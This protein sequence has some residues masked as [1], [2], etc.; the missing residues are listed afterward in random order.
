MFVA[1]QAAPQAVIGIQSA[2]DL[3]VRTA[4]D[5]I[6]ELATVLPLPHVVAIVWCIMV[7]VLHTSLITHLVI[8]A[9]KHLAAGQQDLGCG[10]VVVK[11]V[12][13]CTMM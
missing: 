13:L 11:A 6:A 5:I 12:A 2:E 7:T 9:A 8:A 10:P 1:I 4:V 3:A